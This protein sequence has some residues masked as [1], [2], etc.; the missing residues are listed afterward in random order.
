MLI[1]TGLR[2][3]SEHQISEYLAFK[4]SS[5]LTLFPR[6]FRLRSLRDP[7]LKFGRGPAGQTDPGT[8]KPGDAE[9]RRRVGHHLHQAAAQA[10]RAA[11]P[12]QHALRGTALLQSAPLKASQGSPPPYPHTSTGTCLLLPPRPPLYTTN[13]VACLFLE[14]TE[15]YFLFY[16][17]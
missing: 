12:Q 16:F 14:C 1:I 9:P 4:T 15:S 3:N 10:S 13:P 2:M 6:L 7:G 17:C 8:A 5:V 11:F